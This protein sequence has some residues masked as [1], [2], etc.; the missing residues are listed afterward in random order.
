[1]LYPHGFLS[2]CYQHYQIRSR[3][4]SCAISGCLLSFPIPPKTHFALS[5]DRTLRLPTSF[6]ISRWARLAVK[7]RLSRSSWRA[8]GRTHPLILESS[9]RIFSS[10]GSLCLPSLSSLEST[11]FD[12][13]V[14]SFLS[15][16]SLLPSSFSPKYGSRSPGFCPTSRS[17][18]LD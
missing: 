17:G 12:Y 10:R 3:A 16:L 9:S 6:S 5:S 7:P 2:W 14:H 1:M 11:F 18:D 13:R 15:M 4:A 8:V